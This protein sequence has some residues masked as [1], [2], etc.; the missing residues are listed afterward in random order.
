MT[1]RWTK[2]DIR[3]AVHA[4][5]DVVDAPIEGVEI[6]PDGRLRI[7]TAPAKGE[8]EFQSANDWT[9]H[10]GEKEVSRA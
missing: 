4:V 5:R 2:A 8:A 3:R 1:A 6:W 9:A 7:L 10:A